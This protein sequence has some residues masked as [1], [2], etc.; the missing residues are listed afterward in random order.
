MSAIMQGLVDEASVA[1]MTF[2]ILVLEEK[3]V[4]QLIKI[5]E[6]SCCNNR[7]FVDFGGERNVLFK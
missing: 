4:F 3:L 2:D 7:I 1:T 5:M 6:M